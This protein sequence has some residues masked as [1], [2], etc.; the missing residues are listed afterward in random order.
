MKKTLSILLTAILVIGMSSTSLARNYYVSLYGGAAWP[1]DASASL[2][3]NNN[4][5]NEL[6]SA[7]TELHFDSGFAGTAAIGCDLG[8][9]RLEG[10]IGYQQNAVN[11]VI[12]DFDLDDDTDLFDEGNYKIEEPGFGDVSLSTIMFNGYYDIPVSDAGFE[13]FLTG[14]IGLAIAHFDMVGPGLEV[15]YSESDD[16]VQS[17]YRSEFTET[18]WAWQVGAGIGIPLGNN[19]MLDARYRYLS[20]ADFTTRD[21][22]ELFIDE[23]MNISFSNHSALLGLRVTL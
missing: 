22:D 13:L 21:D 6:V 17:A 9:F 8:D 3:E 20:T 15:Y 18:S 23:P 11:T 12:W 19:V 7:L 4:A 2:L 10:E 1:E 5:D 14:G 16:P